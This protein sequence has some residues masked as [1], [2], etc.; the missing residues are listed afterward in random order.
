M[1][2][3]IFLLLTLSFFVWTVTVDDPI[4][5]LARALQQLAELPEKEVTIEWL[6]EKYPNWFSGKPVNVG[7]DGGKV[8]TIKV[9]R[10][11]GST[12]AANSF[13]NLAF[14]IEMLTHGRDE[15][16]TIY[17][18]LINKTGRNCFIEMVKKIFPESCSKETRVCTSAALSLLLGEKEEELKKRCSS[19]CFPVNNERGNLNQ[20][21]KVMIN[22]EIPCQDIVNSI[23]T[24]VDKI[25][26][27]K[28]SSDDA[29]LS[30]CC[31]KSIELSNLG[32]SAGLALPAVR[33]FV[34]GKDGLLGIWLILENR[35]HAV[36]LVAQ[37]V[38]GKILYLYADSLGGK[39]PIEIIEKLN[40]L[41]SDKKLFEKRLIRGVM[42]GLNNNFWGGDKKMGFDVLNNVFKAD[43]YYRLSRLKGF[44]TYR[45]FICKER[46]KVDDLKRLLEALELDFSRDDIKIMYPYYNKDTILRSDAKTQRAWRDDL[47]GERV[48]ELFQKI[49]EFKLC[50]KA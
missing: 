9:L 50:E 13:R 30:S 34:A 37:K 16:A 41:L 26:Q 10:Q 48:V 17:D 32:R 19:M 39:A 3:I 24:F 45:N 14:F 8:Y 44:R 1:K 36:A 47:L 46:K 35:W 29:F 6:Y 33:Q 43:N 23:N 40:M 4:K 31:F 20:L 11:S 5:S 21:R 27:R 42:Y 18:R 2:R 7:T 15:V 28:L 22:F 49:D 12:C 25:E 38:G